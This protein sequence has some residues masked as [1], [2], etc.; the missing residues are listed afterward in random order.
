MPSTSSNITRI[1]Y[2]V[3][4]LGR[5]E[6]LEI[7]DEIQTIVYSQN[8]AQTKYLDPSTGLPPYLATVD[9][10]YDYDC[11]SN[12]RSTVAVFSDSPISSYS[13]TRPS[14]QAKRYYY[15]NKGYYKAAVASYDA[16]R[17]VLAR[18]VFQE[19][20]GTTTTKFYHEYYMQ[21]TE[22]TTESVELTL[23]EHTHYLLRQGVTAMLSSEE[24][25]QTGFDTSV[26]D[27][28]ALRIRKVLNRGQQRRMGRTP[29]RAEHMNYPEGSRGYYI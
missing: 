11:P 2:A 14:P 23:P 17:G 21:P 4:K 3:P 10:Q 24:Y 12:C 28:L 15:H 9:G 5:T 20:P 19:N 29:W 6:I 1:Q 26:M 8:T 27:D 18:V 7:L 22:L 25:G 13:R 16:T